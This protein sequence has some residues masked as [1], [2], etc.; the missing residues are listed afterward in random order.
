MLRSRPANRRRILLLISEVRDKGSEGKV[1]DSLLDI[2]MNNVELYSVD[3][4]RM[5]AGFVSRR[6]RSRARIIILRP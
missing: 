2:Q 3:I 5:M 1:R 4:S 6:A